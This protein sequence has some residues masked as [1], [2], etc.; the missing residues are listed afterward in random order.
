MERA[1]CEAGRNPRAVEV[2]ADETARG[3]DSRANFPHRIARFATAR[4][5]SVAISKH[6]SGSGE[7]LRLADEARELM[8]C[9]T[10]LVFRSYSTIDAIRLHGMRSCRKHLLCPSCAISRGS[11][12][13]RAYVPKHAQVIADTPGL[14]AQML[15]LTV[16][17]GPDLEE[18]F[19]HLV[20]SQ[21]KFFKR[22]QKNRGSESERILGA[23]YSVEVKRG[24][25]S[26]LW[27]PHVHMFILVAD[28][29]PVR[30]GVLASE[31]FSITGDSHQVDVHDVYGDPVEAF[32]EVFKYAIK[33]SDLE[34]DD[35]VSA[36]LTLRGRHL[37][38][39]YGLFH[40]VVVGE[41][42]ADELFDDDTLPYLDVMF[43]YCG[44]SLG[45]QHTGIVGSS[46]DRARREAA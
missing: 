40:G 29:S 44:A 22:R 3:F 12:M 42:L 20:T 41:E 14:R 19:E 36:Y 26:G 5:R 30:P 9:R 43:A 18:R 45:Y 35:N 34:F 6:I 15:T 32:C 27:H 13:L 4:E 7:R 21:R 2:L 46:S 28:H 11:K 38:G 16:R 23:V 10:Y 37:I 33:F 17:D 31:W 1:L 8:E 25:G 39:T 24:S